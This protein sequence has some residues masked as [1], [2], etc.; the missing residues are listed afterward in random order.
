M[1]GDATI[2]I[3]PV[4]A[5]VSSRLKAIRIKIGIT[6]KDLAKTIGVTFQQIQKYE[7]GKNRI[8]AS[9]LYEFSKIMKVPISYFFDG[10][11]DG[12]DVEYDIDD[13]NTE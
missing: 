2:K 11:E 3:N 6:Q 1:N 10:Y 13:C 9:R 12:N 5:Y 7:N 4:D 8:S